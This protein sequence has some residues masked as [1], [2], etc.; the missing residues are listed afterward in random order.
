MLRFWSKKKGRFCET[1]IAGARLIDGALRRNIISQVFRIRCGRCQLIDGALRRIL[2]SQVLRNRYSRCKTHRRHDIQ[3][4]FPNQIKQCG[5]MLTVRFCETDIA[6][7]DSQT[8]LSAVY[9]VV[10]KP[11]IVEKR[12]KSLGVQAPPDLL[13]FFDCTGYIFSQNMD[14]AKR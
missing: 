6:G 8:A 11:T 1:D 3:L 5:L 12:H 9:F 7:A 13:P 4:C 10:D 2:I 14:L